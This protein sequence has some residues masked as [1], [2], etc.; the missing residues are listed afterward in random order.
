MSIFFRNL[1]YL[2]IYSGLLL[3]LIF[4]SNWC[5][6]STKTKV[7]VILSSDIEPYQQAWNG[8]KEFYDENNI[9]L[10]TSEYHLSRLK[11]DLII[12]QLVQ[13]NP[14][15][16]FTIGPQALRFAMEGIN[17]IPVIFSM[18]L[19]N[20]IIYNSNFT[21]VYIDVPFSIKLKHIKEILPDLK[22][23]GVIYSP[24]STP[25]FND[26]L[27]G[28]NEIGFQLIGRKVSSRKKFKDAFG[29]ISKQIGCFLMIPDTN[30]YF[31]QSIKYLILEGL[32]KELPIIGLSSSYTKAGAFVSFES[33]Y[34]DTGKQAG[35]IAFRV[36]K[37]ESLENIP[38]VRP[39]NVKYSLN[40]LVAERLGISIPSNIIKKSSEVFGR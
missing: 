1:R 36:L 11:S 33:N 22:K 24:K 10:N 15:I 26:I 8:F 25:I 19:N 37:G 13:D 28:C 29:D 2:H 14:D 17:N 21:G 39:R 18:V 7:S 6:A 34:H 31:Q 32:R 5:F 16:V 12:H 40:L 4:S 30:I 27:K 38:P 9:S 23:I 35:E 20:G 3:L